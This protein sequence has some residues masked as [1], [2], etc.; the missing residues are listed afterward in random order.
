MIKRTN[1]K[2]KGTISYYNKMRLNNYRIK[3]II[4]KMVTITLFSILW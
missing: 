1:S 4:N 2:N 3:S